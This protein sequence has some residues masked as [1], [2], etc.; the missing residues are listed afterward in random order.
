MAVV[1]DTAVVPF[2]QDDARERAM[3]SALNLSTRPSRR[4]DEEDGHLEIGTGAAAQTLLFE[5]KSSPVEE[6]FGTGRDTGL[7]KLVTWERFHFAFAWFEP[8]DNLPIRIWYGSPVMMQSWIE[9]E[10]DYISSDLILVDLLPQNV[11]DNELD[12]L[13]GTKEAYGY[14]EISRIVKNQWKTNRA[15]GQGN[16][17][18]EYADLH[19]SRRVTENRYSRE[20]ALRAVRDRVRYLLDRGSTVNNRSIPK[21]YVLGN[22]VELSGSGNGWAYSLR[23]AVGDYLGNA[24]HQDVS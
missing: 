21:S 14:D 17:Y 15:T 4:R 7:R 5:C 24:D 9:K 10:K 18:V 1:R 6:D 11:G 16:L 3:V 23:K 20:V 13:L 19:R 12:A 22:C 2:N 8:R